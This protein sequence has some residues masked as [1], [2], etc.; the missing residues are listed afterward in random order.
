[1]KNCVCRTLGANESTAKW[2]CLSVSPQTTT[3]TL[4][5]TAVVAP[6]ARTDRHDRQNGEHEVG[7]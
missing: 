6:R 4:K 3:A 7:G 1:M 5:K 2:P